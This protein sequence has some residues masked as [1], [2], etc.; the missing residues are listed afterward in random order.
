MNK[1]IL[2]LFSLMLSACS[3]VGVQQYA[4]EQPRLDLQ[5]YFN[6]EITGWGMV[7]DR[8]GSGSSYTISLR[9]P[10][11]TPQKIYWQRQ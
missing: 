5:Q 2:I 1:S 9:S 7:Q 3:G 11:L 10:H 8:S 6:G 4:A